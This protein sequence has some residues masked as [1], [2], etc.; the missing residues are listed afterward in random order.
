MLTNCSKNKNKMETSLM[1]KVSLRILNTQC[2]NVFIPFTHTSSHSEFLFHAYAQQYSFSFVSYAYPKAKNII[3]YDFFL[4]VECDTKCPPGLY[5]DNCE[6]VCRCYNN[7]SCDA[8]TGKCICNRGWTGVDCTQPCPAGYYGLGCKEK[9]P[10]IVYGNKTCDH[11]TGEYVCRPGY[12]GITCE[13]PCPDGTYG[14]GC[15]LKCMC[16][17][18][19]ECNHIT[20]QCQCAPGWTGTS[21]N[22]L[23]PAG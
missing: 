20:G 2:T 13:H 21:C 3:S 8:Q 14:P 6:T 18:G 7:S 19:A 4:G 5:G 17:N 16:E 1:W 23:C 11:V 22:I 15:S 12:L 9:C 10:A